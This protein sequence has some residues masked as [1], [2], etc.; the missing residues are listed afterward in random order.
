MHVARDH[1][2]YA[3]M[4]I[5]L[6][7]TIFTNLRTLVCIILF[8]LCTSIDNIQDCE[9]LFIEG[10]LLTVSFVIESFFPLWS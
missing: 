3:S 8:D 10:P 1:N 6:L 5:Y 2:G 9:G 7:F 4:V